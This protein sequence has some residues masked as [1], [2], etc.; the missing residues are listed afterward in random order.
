MKITVTGFRPFLG[1]TS[2]PSEDLACELAQIFPEVRAHVLP[3]EYGHSF[4]L[5]RLYL[6]HDQPDYLIMLGQAAGRLKICFE[7]IGLN[8]VQS[9]HPDEAGRHLAAGPILIDQPLALMSEFPVDRVVSALKKENLPVDVS[10]SAGAFVCNDLYFRALAE[11]PDKKPVFIHVPLIKDM[12]FETQLNI[13][14]KTVSE[15]LSGQ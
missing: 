3:V 5:L 6:Q 12:D 10:F 2:N 11:F 7:K 9:E 14:K 13:L 1:A 8:W 15:L 4:E